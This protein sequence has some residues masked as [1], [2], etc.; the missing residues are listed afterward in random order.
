MWVG[1]RIIQM[2]IRELLTDAKFGEI[3]WDL[4]SEDGVEGSVFLIKG[5]FMGKV[6]R[7]G[8]IFRFSKLIV[9]KRL[10]LLVYF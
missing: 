7:N 6:K 10:N 1:N 5:A 8:K 3:I 4:M 2:K 9:K